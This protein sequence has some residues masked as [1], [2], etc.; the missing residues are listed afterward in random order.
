MSP[1]S[2][3]GRALRDLRQR[4]RLT[5]RTFTCRL[6]RRGWGPRSPIMGADH[7][8]LRGETADL[9]HMSQLTLADR[10]RRRPPIEAAAPQRRRCKLDHARGRRYGAAMRR[11]WAVCSSRSPPPPRRRAGAGRRPHRRGQRLRRGQPA[12]TSAFAFA[13]TTLEK[14]AQ[15][16]REV[17]G[18]SPT[19]ARSRSARSGLRAAPRHADPARR[20]R[21]VPGS[22]AARRAAH[23]P[24]R[25][26]DATASI[27]SAGS[28]LPLPARRHARL[29]EREQLDDG[30]RRHRAGRRLRRAHGGC[31]HRAQLF[32][33]VCAAPRRQRRSTR[34]TPSTS[35]SPGRRSRR[36]AT[37]PSRP[38]SSPSSRRS[39]SATSWHSTARS[40]TPTTR[41][42]EGVHRSVARTAISQSLALR[43][44]VHGVLV[45]VPDRARRLAVQGLRPV[46]EAEESDAAGRAPSS[47]SSWC[48]SSG[49]ATATRSVIDLRGRIEGHFAGTRLLRGVGAARRRRRRWRATRRRPP[50]TR[51]ATRR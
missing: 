32:R 9:T 22:D 17:E 51:R 50:T 21:A 16:K 44:S 37:T 11:A 6:H 28:A 47:A 34:S 15:I 18:L 36:S 31:C 12:S 33:G 7:R 26:G 29:R 30:P 20:G 10:T 49:R 1:S 46:A 14:R 38:G 42:S 8:H 48:R 4:R 13:T 23:H 24:R 25:A 40:P 35:G 19:Q 3:G 39:R 2:F 5:A 41:V 27:K 43:R 45:H